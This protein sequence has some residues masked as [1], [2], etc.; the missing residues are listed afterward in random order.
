MVQMMMFWT[1]FRKLVTTSNYAIDQ[2]FNLRSWKI[3]MLIISENE[4]SI[5]NLL[6]HRLGL[7]KVPHNSHAITVK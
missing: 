6:L 5:K 1:G 3:L 4:Y 7:F 2:A